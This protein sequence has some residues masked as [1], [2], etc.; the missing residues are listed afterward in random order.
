MSAGDDRDDRLPADRSP[1]PTKLGG[2]AADAGWTLSGAVIGGLL[3]GYM[4][5]EYFGWNPAAILVG[6]FVGIAVGLYNLAKIMLT[7]R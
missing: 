1:L 7:R 5:G 4:I 3:L 2:A 6:L